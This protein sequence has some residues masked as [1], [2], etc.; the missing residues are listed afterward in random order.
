MHT[1][2]GISIRFPRVTR[3][4]HDKDW[5]TATTLDELRVLFKRK[6]ESVDFGRLLD[7]LTDVKTSSRKKPF[8]PAKNTSPKKIESSR[9]NFWDEPSTSSRA[10][11]KL[12]KNIKEEFEE[13]PLQEGTLKRRK[14]NDCDKESS[15]KIL[16]EK[17]KLKREIKG[18]TE[19]SSSTKLKKEEKSNSRMEGSFDSSF[20]ANS[21]DSNGEVKVSDIISF[22]D[23]NY[24]SISAKFS[25]FLSFQKIS[26]ICLIIALFNYRLSYSI[27]LHGLYKNFRIFFLQIRNVIYCCKSTYSSD[28]TFCDYFF[29]K[30]KNE[31]GRTHFTWKL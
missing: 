7:T 17:K 11:K 29:F 22:F 30:V 12:P 27:L 25:K 31:T 19:N 14:G 21:I 5:L 1:A 8:D 26:Q 2:D 15:D 20:D 24:F 13:I 18:K 9:M 6:P 3:I 16:L 10:K 4:R 23:K 28:I